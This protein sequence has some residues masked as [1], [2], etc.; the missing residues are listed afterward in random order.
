VE[1]LASRRMICYNIWVVTFPQ[2]GDVVMMM[3]MMMM[4]FS[5]LT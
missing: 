4:K 5:S 1:R 2:C 3:M